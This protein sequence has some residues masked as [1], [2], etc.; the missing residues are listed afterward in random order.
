V[1][2]T[3]S[4]YKPADEE[5][6]EMKYQEWRFK[7]F[8]ELQNDLDVGSVSHDH[9]D[10]VALIKTVVEICMDQMLPMAVVARVIPLLTSF[11]GFAVISEHDRKHINMAV[12]LLTEMVTSWK[13]KE[14]DLVGPYDMRDFATEVSQM[15]FKLEDNKI[16]YDGGKYS[17][18][19]TVDFLYHVA[20]LLDF[21]QETTANEELAAAI[22]T[23]HRALKRKI[24]HMKLLKDFDKLKHGKFKPK[25]KI[26]AKAAYPLPVDKVI[27]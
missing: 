20:K 22:K 13:A 26:E 3:M 15:I 6:M 19:D 1:L 12:S 21:A 18:R 9:P 23:S 17:D 2:Q 10:N 14:A 5:K 7:L 24:D 11:N 25:S 16:A 27:L 8:H 4:D